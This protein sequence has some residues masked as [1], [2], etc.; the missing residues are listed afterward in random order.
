MDKVLIEYNKKK[1]NESEF[2]FGRIID[3][4][5]INELFLKINFNN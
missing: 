5:N 2:L 3:N 4:D 1:T